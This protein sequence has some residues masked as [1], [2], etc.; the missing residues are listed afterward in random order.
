MG[1]ADM[2]YQQ[3]QLPPH[4]A[5]LYCTAVRIAVKCCALQLYNSTAH[6]GTVWAGG[7][8]LVSQ[9]GCL[10]LPTMSPADW[11][12]KTLKA[13]PQTR[14]GCTGGGAVSLLAPVWL[15]LPG[16]VFFCQRLPWHEALSS[17]GSCQSHVWVCPVG[18]ELCVTQ[19][20]CVVMMAHGGHACVCCLVCHAGRNACGCLC[21][22]Q[23]ASCQQWATTGCCEAAV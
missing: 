13:S 1:I 18:N 5:V 2:V 9:D 17:T 20:V 16:W 12:V 8:L 11:L 14:W 7:L 10:R 15:P 22:C 6:S 3:P 23:L 4:Q 19:C 21:S